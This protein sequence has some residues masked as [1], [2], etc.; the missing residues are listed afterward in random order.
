MESVAAKSPA[1]E[2]AA[3][4]ENYEP[5]DGKTRLVAAVALQVNTQTITVDDVLRKLAHKLQDL[6]KTGSEQDFRLRAG[7][8]IGDK[9]RELVVDAMSAA[10]AKKALDDKDKE[11]LDKAVAERMQELILQAGGAKSMLDAKMREQGSSLEELETAVHRQMMSRYFFEKKYL[12]TLAVTR[13]EMWNYYQ[14]HLGEFSTQKLVR[15]QVA[16]F[17]DEMFYD[18]PVRRP[19][20]SQQQEARKQAV[21]AAQK[22]LARIKAGEDFGALAARASGPG[23]PGLRGRHT[24]YDARRNFP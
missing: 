21:A 6:G 13:K 17:L 14:Q 15:M 10:E 2:A 16:A 8:L 24:R 4:R 19:T 11:A 3:G 5:L 22:A 1:A 18:S 9:T 7:E 23:V 20:K 12:A